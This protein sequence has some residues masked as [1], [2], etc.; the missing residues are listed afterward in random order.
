MSDT[1]QGPQGILAGLTNYGDQKFS[2]YL[3]R[4]FAKSMGYSDEALARPIVGIAYTPSGFNNCHRHFPELLEAVKR[5]VLMAGGL[6]VE[7]PTISLGEVF[8]SPTSLKYRNLMA[9]DTEAMIKAQPMDSVVLM[10]G[11]DKTVPAQLMAAISADLPAI[12]LVAGP[13]ST[14]KHRGERLGAC[15]DCR[16]F[17]ARYRAGDVDDAEIGQ[18]EGRLATTAGTCSVMGTASTMACLTEAMGMSL[19]GSAAAPAVHA[20][21]LRIAEE[22]G[23][24][25]VVLAAE[26]IKPSAIVTQ[27]SIENALRVLLAVSGSTNAL[28]HLTAIARRAGITIDLARFNAMSDETPVLVNLKPVGSH[29]MDD[30][31]YA[32]GVPAVLK[33]LADLLHLDCATVA[34][35]TIGELVGL[36]LPDPTDRAVIRSRQEPIDPQGGLI[37]VFGS[38]A[39]QG[40]IVKR[41]AADPQ[42]M[43]HEGR[44]VVFESLADLAARIDAPDLDINANDIIVLKNAGPRSAAAMPEAGH[45][46]IPRR[47]AAA[48][49]KDMLRISDAR[50]SGTAYGAIVLHVTPEAHIGGPLLYVESGDRIRISA[51]S[52]TLDLLVN[53]GEMQRRREARAMPHEPEGLRGYDRLYQSHVLG[54]DGGVDFDFC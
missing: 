12:Q 11:C 25:A 20:D 30:F 31:F 8:L 9:M 10:G 37:A 2:A 29:Y 35:P 18:V 40:A 13:M 44:A 23:K 39:P 42:L 26:Q 6:P 38:L 46:P 49:V 52:K 14:S 24:R 51:Q 50:M 27:K 54:A 36:P 21:R 53:P 3:R 33:E 16:R 28:I 47:L 17:W 43:E 32:G 1:K 48:G 7:F 15:T 41:A 45:L 19:P 34:G 22:T 5:G 4:S